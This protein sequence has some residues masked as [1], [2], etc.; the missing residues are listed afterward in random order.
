MRAIRYHGFGDASVISID[1]IDRL[2]PSSDEVLI[3]TQAIGVNPSDILKREGLFDDSLPIIPGYDV[4][5]IV[6]QVGDAV[7]NF[8]VGDRVYGFIPNTGVE[9]EGDRQG[10]YAEYVTAHQRQLAKLPKTVSFEEGAALPT[11][12]ITAW[13]ALVEYGELKPDQTCFIHG[14]SGGVGH[15]AVQIAKAA[16]AETVATASGDKKMK[17]VRELGA[18]TVLDYTND[19]EKQVEEGLNRSPNIILDHMVGKYLQFDV[20]VIQESGRI[21]FIGENH[22]RAVIEDV[23]KAMWKDVKILPL[24]ASNADNHGEILK[25]L[26]GLL[27]SGALQVEVAES[28]AMEEVAEA[29]QPVAEDSSTGTAVLYP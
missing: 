5:G 1:E 8:E 17:R 13:L 29:Q 25:S 10:T 4:A 23:S 16:S 11:A 18:D 27:T 15:I 19:L 7:C 6:E 21:V 2:M 12:G 26:A 20:D 22:D 3:E 24:A 9:N 28:F 14:G